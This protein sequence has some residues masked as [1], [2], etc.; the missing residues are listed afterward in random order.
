MSSDNVRVLTGSAGEIVIAHIQG[1]GLAEQSAVVTQIGH[2]SSVHTVETH[3]IPIDEQ[4]GRIKQWVDGQFNL[5]KAVS[6]EGAVIGRSDAIV[7]SQVVQP[8]D[9]WDDIQKCIDDAGVPNWVFNAIWIACGVASALTAGG[10]CLAC[11][12]GVAGIYR[13]KVANCIGA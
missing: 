7:D 10:G 13:D 5:D 1:S 2:D 8:A 12:L 4:S 11:A 6:K 3:F 9:W